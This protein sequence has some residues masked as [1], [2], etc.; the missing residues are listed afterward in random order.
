MY[1]LK[2]KIGLRYIVI[3]NWLFHVIIQ[4]GSRWI[5]DIGAAVLKEYEADIIPK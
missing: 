1:I 5:M 4:H 3:Y 2:K